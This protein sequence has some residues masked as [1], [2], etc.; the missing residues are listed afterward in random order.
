MV[1]GLIPLSLGLALCW[2]C[3]SQD[4]LKP[5]PRWITVPLEVTPQ[6]KCARLT[7]KVFVES[8]FICFKI[9]PLV[10]TQNVILLDHV[11]KNDMFYRGWVIFKLHSGVGHS[12]L[13]QIDGVGHVF[14]IYHIF[15][16]SG[17]PII[18][19]YFLTSPLLEMLGTY[20]AIIKHCI[21]HESVLEMSKLQ[22]CSRGNK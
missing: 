13:C 19:L 10:Q 1:L 11:T 12:G 7:V 21:N 15:K 6:V 16:C 20:H 9:L 14:S 17:S 18:P 3:G 5:F 2:L 22:A 4:S 8:I